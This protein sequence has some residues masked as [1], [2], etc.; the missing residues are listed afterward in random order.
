ME[1]NRESDT[2]PSHKRKHG[3]QSGQKE[4]DGGK[5]TLSVTEIRFVR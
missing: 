5:T 2:V 3:R 4:D 1:T